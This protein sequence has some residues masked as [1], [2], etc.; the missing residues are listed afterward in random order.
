MSR[1]LLILDL[2]E[3]L[4]HASPTKLATEPDFRYE[5]YFVYKR[6]AVDD[7]LTEAAREFEL[8]VWSSADDA[9]VREIVAK[10][11]PA[12]AFAFVWGRSRCIY[13]RNLETDTYCW[14]KQ[15]QK[16]RRQGYSLNRMLI[17]DDTAEKSR[18]NY[19]N[20]V[21]LPPF[22]GQPTD[23]VLPRLLAYLR[24]LATAENVRRVEKRDWLRRQAK[25]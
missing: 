13:R 16:L 14:E 2:D 21:H 7:F 22:E 1:L 18:A 25:G 6:P 11:A 10:L 20:A 3:T 23:D 17:V 9:Y 19:G 4:L 24:Q 12:A 5:Q 15:L 8:A